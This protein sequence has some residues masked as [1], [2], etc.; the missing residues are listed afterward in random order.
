MPESMY[1]YP[2]QE[3]PITSLPKSMQE[4]ALWARK[5]FIEEPGLSQVDDSLL[6]WMKNDEDGLW[7]SI[8]GNYS[9][10]SPEDKRIKEEAIKQQ[11][12]SRMKTAEEMAEEIY[13]NIMYQSRIRGDILQRDNFTCQLCGKWGGS[14]LHIHHILKRI[15]GG[16]DHLDNL[17][18]LCPKC[19]SNADRSLYN[20]DWN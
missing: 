19:H 13:Q 15:Q 1:S 2:T 3:D 6:V 7:Y 11:Y 5:A 17:I 14:K 8:N 18:T 12:Q 20:P 4:R 10:S 9:H 16:T